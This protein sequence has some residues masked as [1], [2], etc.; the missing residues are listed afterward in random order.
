LATASR[1]KRRLSS[2]RR[3]PSYNGLTLNAR[4]VADALLHTGTVAWGELVAMAVVLGG[5]GVAVY[6]QHVLE[7]GLYSDDWAFASIT[8]HGGGPFEVYDQLR[9]SVGFRPLGVLS[10]YVR[11][12]LLDGHARWHLALALVLTVLLCLVVYL[13]LR[14]LRIERLHAAAIALL[15]LVCPYADAT[16]LWATGSGANAAIAL[17]LLGV[18][19]AL[20]A[21]SIRE[22]RKSIALHA[23]AVAFYLASL[24]QYEVA[25]VAICASGLL[26]LTRAGWRRALPRALADVAV[27]SA[28]IGLIVANSAVPHTD[29]YTRHARLLYDGGLRILTAIALPHG[30]PR[31]GTV[32]G[33]LFV[34]AAGGALVAALLPRS[35]PE[36]RELLRWLVV[37]AG[38]IVLAATGYVMFTGAIDYYHPLSPGLANRTNAIATLGFIASVYAV[39]AVAGTLL[40][41]G[42]RWGRYLAAGVPVVTAVFLFAGYQDRLEASAAVWDRT[43]AHEKDV[44]STLQEQ[45]PDPPPSSTIFTF[46]HP[47][48]SENPGLPIFSSFWELRGAVQVVYDDPSVAAYPALPGSKLICRERGAML[49]GYPPEYGDQYGEVFFVDIP[50]GRVSQVRTFGECLAA[51]PS[52]QPG[53]H[54][55]SP[56]ARAASHLGQHAPGK[57]GYALG[58]RRRHPH[59]ER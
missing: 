25:Y 13:F 14:A 23:V 12:R 19:V 18:V 29:S 34:V 15:V 31:T 55:A 52:Y 44:L 3:P 16:R 33:L 30:T 8:Q 2:M 48:V 37:A 17:W 32:V 28:T 6:G 41:R 11:F 56:P 24:L 42:L 5:A 27:A 21:L 38:G 47:T 4:R 9:G 54:Q 59:P 57:V 7:G 40:F 49:A 50:T 35:S 58:I 1:T 26:Y 51:A 45:I 10:L 43:Y 39:S 36:R 46:G 22:H 53:P 20:H